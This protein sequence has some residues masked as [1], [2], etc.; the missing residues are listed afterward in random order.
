MVTEW[1]RGSARTAVAGALALAVLVSSTLLLGTSSAAAGVVARDGK[2][3]A[4]YKAKG[5]GKGTL[6]VVRRAKAKCPKRWKKVAWSV[7]GTPG[8]QG[9]AGA[10]GETGPAGAQG[11]Q[12]L[13]GRNENVVVNELEDKVTELLTKVQSLEAILKGVSN[14]QLKEAIAAVAK[15]EAL[16]TTVGSLCTQT[17]ALTTQAN[18]LLGSMEGLNTILD[19]LLVAFTPPSLP[20]PLGSFS[21]P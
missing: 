7:A 12:G 6:R 21:C 20:A 14:T 19:T 4:C 10:R 3:H 18:S 1:R 2:I 16:E 15:V 11:I 5:K 8:P 9:E 17:G 13:P